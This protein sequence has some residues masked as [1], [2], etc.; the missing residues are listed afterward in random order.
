MAAS[1]P[2]SSHPLWEAR[3]EGQHRL[4][5]RSGGEATMQR[6]YSRC[7]AADTFS[8]SVSVRVSFTAAH[9]PLRLHS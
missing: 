7:S 9:P 2:P 6:L 4:R 3:W 5:K 1:R 8:A